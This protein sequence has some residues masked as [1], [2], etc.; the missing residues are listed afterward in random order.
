TPVISPAGFIIYSGKQFPKWQGHGFIGG[1]SSQ[2]LV[3]VA[4]DGPNAREVARYDMGQRIREVEQGPDG[5]I[6]LLEDGHDGRL[7]KLT[8]RT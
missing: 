2:S 5:A 1:L 8:P 7:L 3:Q 6:W 4:L